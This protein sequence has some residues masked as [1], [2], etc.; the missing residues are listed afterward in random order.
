MNEIIGS[1]CD[2]CAHILAY[3]NVTVHIYIFA[4]LIAYNF[5][6]QKIRENI[7]TYNPKN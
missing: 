7:L 4:L 6:I 2:I 3:Q 1:K 5:S